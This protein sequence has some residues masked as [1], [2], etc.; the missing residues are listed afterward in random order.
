MQLQCSYLKI[1]FTVFSLN[2]EIPIDYFSFASV[3]DTQGKYSIWES[4]KGCVKWVRFGVSVGFWMNWL[5]KNVPE[6]YLK[7]S[8]IVSVSFA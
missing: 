5:S 6:T 2:L 3:G 7:I 8:E 4:F 1:Y